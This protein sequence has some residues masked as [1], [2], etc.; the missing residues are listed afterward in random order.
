VAF[1]NL[2]VTKPIGG[3][4]T[5]TV[6]A[7]TKALSSKNRRA[8]IARVHETVALVLAALSLWSAAI[9]LQALDGWTLWALPLVPAAG[10]AFVRAMRSWIAP[11]VP[12]RWQRA[13]VWGA[14]ALA[15]PTA[16]ATMT[17][18]DFSALLAC[19]LLLIAATVAEVPHKRR[20]AAFLWLVPMTVVLT[21][22]AYGS[23]L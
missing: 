5:K 6:A 16:S 13:V 2:A 20:V 22:V 3:T 10:L 18:I 14:L 19:Q 8:L 1:S 9:Q 21:V 12:V 4:V 7:R 11:K 15:T 17:T 23:T